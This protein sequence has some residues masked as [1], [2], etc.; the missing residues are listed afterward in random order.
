[1]AKPT[2][3]PSDIH[4]ASDSPRFMGTVTFGWS[5]PLTDP[6]IHLEV[7][8]A[9]K[10][11]LQSWQRADILPTFQLGPSPAWQGGAAD[12]KAT[13]KDWSDYSKH[14]AKSVRPLASVAFPVG[15]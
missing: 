1:M 5:S 6:F 13:L 4:V 14:G 9:G 7:S 12:G 2:P 8:Q 3:G 11:V 15:A 10:L